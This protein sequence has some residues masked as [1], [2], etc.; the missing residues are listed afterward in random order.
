MPF[1]ESHAKGTHKFLS[2]SL[3]TAPSTSKP[4]SLSEAGFTSEQKRM[5]PL[6]TQARTG[7]ELLSDRI[8]DVTTILTF[9]HLLEKQELGMAMR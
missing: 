6:R 1:S 7:Q 9:R 8:P 4:A 2:M 3:P 5:I